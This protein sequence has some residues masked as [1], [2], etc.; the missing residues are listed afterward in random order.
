MDWITPDLAIGGLSDLLDHGRL[1]EEAVEAVLQL[2]GHPRER[3]T[4]PLPLEILQ[5]PV[6]DREPLPPEFLRAGLDFLAEQRRA[7][8]RVVVACGAGISRSPCFVAACLH[9]EGMA[10]DEAFRLI[11]GA[12]PQICPNRELMRSLLDYFR[13]GDEIAEGLLR[14]T[15]GSGATRQ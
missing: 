4:I 3:A 1:Q 9:T 14:W 11:Q 8:R 5:L 12:R 13:V 6:K 7:G 15:R 2:Y 10:L